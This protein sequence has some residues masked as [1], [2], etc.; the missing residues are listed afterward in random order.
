MIIYCNYCGYSY[1]KLSCSICNAT[2]ETCGCDCA[3][4]VCEEH[5]CVECSEPFEEL[6]DNGMCE[7]CQTLKVLD[8]SSQDVVE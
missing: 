7:D 1:I 8:K 6:D 4:D 5:F 2:I 3:R